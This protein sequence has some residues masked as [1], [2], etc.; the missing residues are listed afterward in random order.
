MQR[1]LSVVQLLP[2]LEVGGVEQGT[3]EIAAALVAGGHRA[4]VVSGGGRLVPKLLFYS[5]TWAPDCQLSCRLKPR[6]STLK[7]AGM[8]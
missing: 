4:V 6:R 7:M 5:P 1:P 3:L 8:G 2:E